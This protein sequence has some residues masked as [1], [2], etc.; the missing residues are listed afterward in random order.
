MEEAVDL[1]SDR[2]LMMMTN[3]RQ[4]ILPP[5]QMVKMLS[6]KFLALTCSEERN[7]AYAAG[8]TSAPSLLRLA[9]PV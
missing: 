3:T 9:N 1:S 4:A 5:T 6:I 2:L 7:S 8:C